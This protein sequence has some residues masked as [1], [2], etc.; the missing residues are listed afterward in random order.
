MS[1]ESFF[2]WLAWGASG[3]GALLG[4]W[5]LVGD[6]SRGRRRCPRCWYSMEGAAGLKC[7]ECGREVRNERRLLRSRRRWRWAVVALLVIVSAPAVGVWPAAAR[8]GWLAGLPLPVVVEALPVSGN[9][10]PLGVE[11]GSVWA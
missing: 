4:A 2:H 9:K 7:P 3:I 6:R 10:G 8:D 1:S 5:A 11:P